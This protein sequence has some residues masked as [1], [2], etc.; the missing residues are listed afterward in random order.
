MKNKS[1]TDDYSLERGLPVSMEAERSILGAILLDNQCYPEVSSIIDVDDFSLDA[2]R[3]IYGRM[4]QLAD[5]GRNVDMITL[6]D[7]LDNRKEIEAI[8]GVSYISSLIDGVP[9]RPSVKHYCDI[10]RDKARLRGLINISQNAIAEAIEHSEEANEVIGRTQDAIGMLFAE[11][12]RSEGQDAVDIVTPCLREIWDTANTAD[13]GK[14]LGYTFDILELDEM[15]GGLRNGEMTVIAG[16]PGHGK[17]VLALQVALANMPA[18]K[19][20][21]FACADM[22]KQSIF[23]RSV[24][25][26]TGIHFKKIRN[27][28]L[29][30]PDLEKIAHYGKHVFAAL[31]F[32]IDDTT[33]VTLTQLIGRMKMLAKKGY[34][35]FVVD[36]VQRVL[37]PWARDARAALNA[38]SAALDAFAKNYNAHV[39]ALSQL[40]KYQNKSASGTEPPPTEND[41]KESA[42]FNEDADTV[43][44]VWNPRNKKRQ[45]QHKDFIFI[46]KQRNGATGVITSDL[47][48]TLMRWIFREDKD[49]EVETPTEAAAT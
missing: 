10:V 46:T 28:W 32:H 33:S 2:H 47:D 42:N 41:I 19:V 8:G 4:K 44:L 24:C 14:L 11:A 48:G 1:N 6:T 25:R 29:K 43:A 38:V 49:K 35:L 34:K 22:S 37:V 45:T 18:T 5:A 16:R 30:P 27:G 36:F 12:D 9:E 15:I 23:N 17:T 7:A 40:S 31:P 21:Y 3:R 39:I 13:N 26:G 20:A